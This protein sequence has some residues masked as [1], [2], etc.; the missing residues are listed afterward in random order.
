MEAKF[1]LS[2]VMCGVIMC[3]DSQWLPEAKLC[4]WDSHDTAQVHNLAVVLLTTE[5]QRCLTEEGNI[6][7]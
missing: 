4:Y 2:R 3:N 1:F 5:L 6:F 7:T